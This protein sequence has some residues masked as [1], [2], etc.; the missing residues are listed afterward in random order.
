[1][2][3]DPNLELGKDLSVLAQRVRNR[4]KFMA[5]VFIFPQQQ[6]APSFTIYHP[7]ILHYPF[8]Q[9]N[10]ATSSS[11]GELYNTTIV[12]QLLLFTYLLYQQLWFELC[13]CVLPYSTFVRLSFWNVKITRRQS[14][15]IPKHWKRAPETI[16][17][18]VS[19][20]GKAL[21]GTWNSTE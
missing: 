10:E 12:S 4:I 3:N 8:T 11:P 5:Q 14:N 18:F 21:K 20:I 19:V 6:V 9:H 2:R 13:V 1:M 17:K 7:F 15:I 16:R